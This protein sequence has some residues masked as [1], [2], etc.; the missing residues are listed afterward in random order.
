QESGLEENTMVIFTSDHGDHD[1][2]HRLEH[3]TALYEEAMRVPFIVSGP[4][5]ARRGEV[6]NRLVSNGL[7][8]LPT[9]CD[10]A[11][12]AP[13]QGRRG[14][15]LRPL[16]EGRDCDWRE[17]VAVECQ[18][19]YAVVGPRHKYGLYDE[20]ENREQLYDLE[21]DPY[22]TRN[23]AGDAD[24]QSALERYRELH[25]RWVSPL[26]ASRPQTAQKTMLRWRYSVGVMFR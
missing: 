3:K 21:A 12:V 25:G 7:D 16:L 18:V 26:E 22:E 11:G 6:E 24:K 23:F 9:L 19:G 4:G 13:P 14:R 10:Y 17:A 20:G 15:S 5:P 2:A 1:S 8:L